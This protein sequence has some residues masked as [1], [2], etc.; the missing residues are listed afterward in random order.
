MAINTMIKA[1]DLINKKVVEGFAQAAKKSFDA[2]TGIKPSV[3]QGF[4]DAPVS[5]PKGKK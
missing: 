3:K 4:K 1:S 5:L 2:A